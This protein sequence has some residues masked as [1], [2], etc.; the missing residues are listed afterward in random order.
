MQGASCHARV[1]HWVGRYAQQALQCDF[2][3]LANNKSVLCLPGHIVHHSSMDYN[4]SVGVRGGAFDIAHVRAQQKRACYIAAGPLHSLTLSILSAVWL[5]VLPA[6]CSC[7][8]AQHISRTPH[9]KLCL[10]GRL[11]RSESCMSALM[12]QSYG[13]N[14]VYL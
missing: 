12:K 5:G 1:Q 6:T 13:Q 2:S 3:I 7:L 9:I 4:M 10:L 11:R 14:G 8:P